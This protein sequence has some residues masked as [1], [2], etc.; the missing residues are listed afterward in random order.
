MKTDRSS[1]TAG[2]TETPID[3]TFLT[4]NPGVSASFLG[5]QLLELLLPSTCRMCD[6]CVPAGDD[7]CAE[8]LS[9]LQSSEHLMQFACPR[10]GRPGAGPLGQTTVTTPV[11]NA[12][13]TLASR[14][15]VSASGKSQVNACQH[16]RRQSYA[17]DC[18]IALW[19]YDS[20]VRNAVVAAKFGSQVALADAL[21][22]RLGAR[23]LQVWGDETPVNPGS[24]AAV[25][26]ERAD[27]GTPP[28][29]IT[30]VPSHLWRRV[31]RGAGGSRVLAKSVARFLRPHWPNAVQTD[32]MRATRQ[33]KKQAWLGEKDRN[34]NVQGAFRVNRGVLKARLSNRHGNRLVGKHVLLIDD[35][36]TTGATATENARVLK[37]A[38]ARRVTVA[39]V[40][41][42]CPR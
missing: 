13:T 26:A 25:P 24:S 7:F 22:R 15:A 8:C 17:F 38:G 23:I 16:C 33:I 32:L 19:T 40:A 27:D 28:D 20:L 6:Q 21:G 4:G 37:Q 42:A 12:V 10:C 1:R 41:R 30:S 5:R 31:Q 3:S 34:A 2:E 36:M 39:V 14:D 11:T 18:C 35:V 9:R 29:L